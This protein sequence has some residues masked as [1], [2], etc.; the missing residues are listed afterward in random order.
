MDQL[1][2]DR[3]HFSLESQKWTF[4]QEDGS[5]WEWDTLRSAW[6]PVLEDQLVRAQQ[7]AYKV[8]GVDESVPVAGVLK[9]ESKKRKPSPSSSVPPPPPPKRKHHQQPPKRQTAVYITHLPPHTTVAL[10]SSVFSKAGLILEDAD[11]R[12]RVKLYHDRDT[13]AF[14]GEALVVYFKEESVHLAVT[15]LDETELELGKGDG[16]LMRVRKAEWNAPPPGEGQEE[17]EGEGSARGEGDRNGAGAAS[18]SG[19]RGTGQHQPDPKKQKQAKRAEKLQA[20]LTDWSSDEES[21]ASLLARARN[22]KIVVLRGMFTLD[23]LDDD[24]S[25]L[26]D[27]KEDVR[28][29]CE[30]WGEVTNVTLY[31]KEEEGIITV[32]FKDDIAAQACIAKM[33]GRFF[34][35]RSIS[36]FTFDGKTKYKKGGQGQDVSLVGTGLDDDDVGGGG[37]TTDGEREREREKDRLERYAEWLEKDE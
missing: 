15:L 34:A 8:D 1:Q 9:R 21:S 12:P 27:L 22:A 32:R 36:A 13:G 19:S 23:E 7:E 3:V 16:M 18:G 4:E 6:V 26:L 29:E 30:T 33:N 24:P 11:G 20:K 28:D 17:G 31:D 5:S 37:G 10:L 25:L 14:K 2:D 35:G